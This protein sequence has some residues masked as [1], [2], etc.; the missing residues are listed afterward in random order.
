MK[1][2]TI[3]EIELQQLLSTSIIM[4]YPKIKAYLYLQR[5]SVKYNV[6]LNMVSDDMNKTIKMKNS[7]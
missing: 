4:E 2:K 3:K 7:V 6:S 5:K 1:L